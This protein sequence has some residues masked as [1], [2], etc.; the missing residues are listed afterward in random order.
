MTRRFLALVAEDRFAAGAPH[1][2][3]WHF[4]QQFWPRWHFMDRPPWWVTA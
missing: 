1:A 2:L 4:G 3:W